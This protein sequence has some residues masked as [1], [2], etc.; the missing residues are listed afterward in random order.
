VDKQERN[1]FFD[2]IQSL[3]FGDRLAPSHA[4][5]IG[6]LV[7]EFSAL[8]DVPDDIR[9]RR[10]SYKAQHPTW[11]CSPEAVLKWWHECG[12]NQE[13]DYA[14]DARKVQEMIYKN[15]SR[16]RLGEYVVLNQKREGTR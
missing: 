14:G 2:M 15:E 16:M 8:T 5:R 7:R 1:A 10:A 13:R 9:R 4:A 6:R 11:T 3:W 12:K